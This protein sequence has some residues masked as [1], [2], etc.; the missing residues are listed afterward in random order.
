LKV[1]NQS[2]S[3]AVS[4]T[5]DTRVP[6]PPWHGTRLLVSWSAPHLRC[7]PTAATLLCNDLCTLYCRCF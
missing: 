3:I 1:Q 4:V 7:Q 5:V 2:G 6:L